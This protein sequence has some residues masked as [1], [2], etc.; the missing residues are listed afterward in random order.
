M[1]TV[2]K[3]AALVCCLCML[4][5]L[6]GCSGQAIQAELFFAEQDNNANAPVLEATELTLLADN[7]VY[8]M[9]YDPAED[10]V[11]FRLKE[12]EELLWSTGV[13]EEEYGQPVENQMTLRALKQLLNLNIPTLENAVVLFTMPAMLVKQRCAVLRMVSASILSF[14]IMILRYLWN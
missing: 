3:V 2:R 6:A 13:T 10:R 8:T 11:N 5:C 14:R 9:E 7:G 1:V 4:L 12:T